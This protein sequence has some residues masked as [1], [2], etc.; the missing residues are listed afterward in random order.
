M[1]IK[2]IKLVN[3]V[4]SETIWVELENVKTVSLKVEKGLERRE[5]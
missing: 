4:I 3:F 1:Y 5:I 2:E